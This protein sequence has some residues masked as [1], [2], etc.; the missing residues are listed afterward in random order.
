MLH[1][2]PRAIFIH[3]VYK[4][5]AVGVNIV[6]PFALLSFQSESAETAEDNEA[7]EAIVTKGKTFK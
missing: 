2:T 4:V 5:S 3:G 7:K 1:Q 6:P